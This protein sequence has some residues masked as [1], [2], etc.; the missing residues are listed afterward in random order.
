M[1]ARRHGLNYL[2]KELQFIIKCYR[3][4]LIPF[5][6]LLVQILTRL[7]LRLMPMGA[8]KFIY[9]YILRNNSN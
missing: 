2:K 6:S 9:K 5:N 4:N 7:P 1:I 8:L 3:E